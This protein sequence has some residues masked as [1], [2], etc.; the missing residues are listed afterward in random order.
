VSPRTGR[1]PGEHPAREDILVAARRRFGEL[2]FK[3]AT[4]RSIAADAGVDPA[5]VIH[6][7][8]NKFDLF[9]AAVRFPLSP[10]EVL[11]A[12]EDT[13]PDQ[14]GE[15]LLRTVIGLWEEPDS[16]DAWLALLRSATSEE[17]AA[18]MLR[19]FLTQAVF[20]RLAGKLDAADAGYRVA[21]VASQVVGLGIARHVL[22]LEPIASASTDELVATVGLTLQRYLTGP[23]TLPTLPEG[24]RKG[25]GGGRGTRG[26]AARGG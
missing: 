26:S 17:Q 18:T 22:R 15:A 8:G 6:Y 25:R 19:E 21:L 23:L 20:E 13:S 4:I 5:L 3:G 2:G 7:Y 14:L 24:V 16:L 9:T 11:D 1:R 12:L 10:R